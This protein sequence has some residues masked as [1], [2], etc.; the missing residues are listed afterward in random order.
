MLA[1][2]IAF[3]CAFSLAA[4]GGDD[5]SGNKGSG[6]NTDDNG[7]IKS[8]KI[9]SAAEWAAAMDFS[10]VTNGTIYLYG[11]DDRVE[12]WFFDGNKQKGIWENYD[13][14]EAVTEYREQRPDELWDDKH[15]TEY[16]YRYDET[17]S[18]WTVDKWAID[19]DT[20]DE[21]FNDG[22]NDCIREYE[23]DENGY[24]GLISQRYADF[25]YD[26]SKYAY[27]ATFESIQD[28]FTDVYV[29]VKFKDG[30]IVEGTIKGVEHL[31]ETSEVELIL[32]IYDLGT[33][34]V[35]LPQV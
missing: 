25:K 13:G 31:E 8:E 17:T 10:D 3:G 22:F 1:T 6:G 14:S 29:E 26:E 24:E 30:K 27:V 11:I 2:T 32:K 35:T 34:T 23:E 5:N 9:N 28:Y 21:R 4:C 18:K 12:Y 15:G 16:T 33:T 19:F 20:F 7:I